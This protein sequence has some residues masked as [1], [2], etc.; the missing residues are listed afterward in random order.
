MGL[1]QR[2]DSGASLLDLFERIEWIEEQSLGSAGESGQLQPVNRNVQ[3][4]VNG[5]R[6]AF[7]PFARVRSSWLELLAGKKENL[8][9]SGGW[10]RGGCHQGQSKSDQ[11]S[12]RTHA[13]VLAQLVVQIG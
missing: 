13:S 8:G 2:A 12:R 7:Q 11:K 5:R 10:R 1:V 6:G 3:P 4:I 9:R